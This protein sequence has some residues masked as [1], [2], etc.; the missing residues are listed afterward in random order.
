MVGG[1]HCVTAVKSATADKSLAWL[2]IVLHLS[3][4]MSGMSG[5]ILWS[6]VIFLVNTQ[7]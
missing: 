5:V 1:G 7:S 2:N 4:I 6:D 3:Y